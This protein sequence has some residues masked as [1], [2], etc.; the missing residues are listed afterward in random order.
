MEKKFCQSC[1]MPLT[2]EILG[3]NA[4][5]SKNEE[6]CMYCFKEGAFTGN[7]TMEEMVEFCSQFV[8]QYNQDSGQHLT[9]DEYKEVLRQYYPNLKR[10][11]LPAAQLPHADSLLKAQLIEEISALGIVDLPKID[12]LFV[13]QGSIV[14]LEYNI[15]GRTIKLLDD[16]KNYWGTQVEKSNANGHCY[17]IACDDEYIVVSEYGQDG[18][19]PELVLVKRRK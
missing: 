12:N 10:W 19:N 6:Y 3:T 7:F 1:G 2:D 13:L 16:D 11:N 9:R 17:G 5:G 4:D 14:N 8:D 15:N 18:S